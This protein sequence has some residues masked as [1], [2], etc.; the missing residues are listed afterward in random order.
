MSDQLREELLNLVS[1]TRALLEDLRDLGIEE[2]L[3]PMPMGTSHFRF[4]L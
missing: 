4:T 3:F 2:C 1:G